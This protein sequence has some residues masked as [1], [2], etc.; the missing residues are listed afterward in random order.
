MIA[1]KESVCQVASAGFWSSG[2]KGPLLGQARGQPITHVNDGV[3]MR[4][5]RDGVDVWK[6][7]Y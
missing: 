4:G 6:D 2:L 7:D 3:G 1:R 5:R